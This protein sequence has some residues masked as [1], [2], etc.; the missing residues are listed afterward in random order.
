MQKILI[1]DDVDKIREIYKNLLLGEG[2]EVFEASNV[3]KAIHII[4]EE[5][6]DLI[7]LDIKKLLYSILFKTN[8][9]IY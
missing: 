3:Y 8:L 1:V 6:I 9:I 4:N 2:Y 7:I 5:S